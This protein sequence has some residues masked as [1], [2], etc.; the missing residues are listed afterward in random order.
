M[1]EL[2]ANVSHMTEQK[3]QLKD[4]ETWT[5]LGTRMAIDAGVLFREVVRVRQALV[6]GSDDYL[7]DKLKSL[8]EVLDEMMRI[9]KVLRLGSA[10]EK[11]VSQLN[12][13]SLDGDDCL[14]L[15]VEALQAYAALAGCRIKPSMQTNFN[16]HEN[17]E[18]TALL[19]TATAS[20]VLHP[21]VADQV[22]FS[23]AGRMGIMHVLGPLSFITFKRWLSTQPERSA[24]QV[25]QDQQQI[26]LV[27]QL[28]AAD[29]LSSTY[30]EY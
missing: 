25:Q 21:N 12:E 5:H 20:G 22:V 3:T 28:I 24:R 6:E 15:G 23:R 8:V 26:A 2:G 29:L 16:R 17:Q 11:M 30:D 4:F 27:E 13:W 10:S 1:G 18:M 14:V 19:R 9:N 7:S